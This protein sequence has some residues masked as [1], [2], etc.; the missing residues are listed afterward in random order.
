MSIAT[1][2][3]AADALAERKAILEGNKALIVERD[4]L[5]QEV[6]MLQPVLA[7]I[8]EEIRSSGALPDL[9]RL[10]DV[11]AAAALAPKRQKALQE[12]DMACMRGNARKLV[13][14][15]QDSKIRANN[16][17]LAAQ[18]QR[19]QTLIATAVDHEHQTRAAREKHAGVLNDLQV[20]LSQMHLQVV[21]AKK[22]LADTQ[23]EDQA[24]KAFR[25]SEEIRLARKATDLDIYEAR[26]RERAGQLD[27]PMQIHV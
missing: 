20:E 6:E 21:E 5:R 3:T 22:S 19:I 4:T 25:A 12:L 18:E 11:A 23:A 9:T 1:T 13:V 26:I 16:A 27:P 2:P 15:L 17:I 8:K 10:Q 14:A 7:A 24:T